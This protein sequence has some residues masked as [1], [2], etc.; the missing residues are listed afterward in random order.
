MSKRAQASSAKRQKSLILGR[1]SRVLRQIAK[2]VAPEDI[3]SA[4]IQNVLKKM[5][6]AMH[7][8]EDSVAIAAPQVGESLRIFVVNSE[9]LERIKSKNSPSPKKDKVFIN[10]E[11]IKLSRS[12]RKMEEGCLS[13]R[14]LY[15]E[16]SRSEKASIRA[17]DENGKKF[18]TGASGLLAQIF[19]HEMDHLDGVLFIDKAT[20]VRDLPPREKDAQAL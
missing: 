10:P 18:Q 9:A 2:P 6:K 8:E 7:A 4:K 12:K 16:V 17:Y 14:W 5:S 20:N 3:P 15:G 19:Q 11:F 1:N 13:V